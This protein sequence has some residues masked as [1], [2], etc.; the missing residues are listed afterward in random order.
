MNFRMKKHSIDG[1]FSFLLFLIFVFCTLVLILLGS[2]IYR[3]GVSHLD[4]NYTARTAVA[5][6]SEKLRQHD[7]P[8]TISFQEM[9]GHMALRLQ[10]TIDGDLFYTYIYYENGAL[11][12]LFLRNGV[13]PLSDMGT[14][15]VSLSS[16]SVSFVPEMDHLLSITAVSEEGRSLST[17]IHLSCI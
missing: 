4:E 10:D 16:F 12:E 8:G 6:V 2:R 1:F 3:N 14:E 13:T 15:I 5:Y 11:C 9:D 17:M 7:E